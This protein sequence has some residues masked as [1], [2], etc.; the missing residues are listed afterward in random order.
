MPEANQ[1]T[2]TNKEL[3]ALLM[4]QAG[5][6]EGKWMLLT[7]FGFGA[8]HLGPS[9]DKMAPGAFAIINHMGIQRA[10][11]EVPEEMTIDAAEINRERAATAKRR[12]SLRSRRATS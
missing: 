9:P 10:G 8:S 2:F 12:P 3:L 1:Y 5:V 6:R 4:K 11:P 7:N